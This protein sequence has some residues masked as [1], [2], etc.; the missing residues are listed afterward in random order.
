[1]S[2]PAVGTDQADIAPGRAGRWAIRLGSALIPLAHAAGQNLV[3]VLGLRFMTD[4]LAISAGAAG[5][6]FAF[7][8]I[9]DGF[10]DPAVG[11]W[12]DRARTP[13][14]RRLPFLFA[15]GIAMP[16]GLAM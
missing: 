3:T 11:A 2:G 15:G 7:V 6:I 10:A 5:A 12:S 16:L 1:M 4:S 14:G 9:Y 13:W 8:K